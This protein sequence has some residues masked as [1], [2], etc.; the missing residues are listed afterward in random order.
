M[1]VSGDKTILEIL[2]QGFIIFSKNG[3]INKAELPKYGSLTIKTQ[4]GQPLFLET[5]KREKLGWLE[6]LEAW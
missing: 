5:Q 1:E 6:K 3:I 4:D 2:E